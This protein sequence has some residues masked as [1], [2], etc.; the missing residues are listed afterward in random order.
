MC[1]GDAFGVWAEALDPHFDL[2]DDLHV[3][4]ACGGFLDDLAVLFHRVAAVRGSVPTDLSRPRLIGG[5]THLICRPAV[6]GPVVALLDDAHGADASSWEL[7]R[8]LST[9]PA[10]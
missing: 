4:E 8:H 3:V 7:L 6:R 2:L 1:V 9:R 5:L 10:V